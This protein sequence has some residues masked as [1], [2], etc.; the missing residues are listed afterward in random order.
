[1]KDGRCEDEAKKGRYVN[2][3]V[4]AKLAGPHTHDEHDND[5]AFKA[6]DETAEAFQPEGPSGWDGTTI[7]E[8]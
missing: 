7:F 6:Y 3:I 1:M 5:S 4:V 2:Y 8:I